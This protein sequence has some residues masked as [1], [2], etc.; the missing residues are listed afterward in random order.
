MYIQVKKDVDQHTLNLAYWS[1]P[2][3][4]YVF[5]RYSANIL[6]P[7]ARETLTIIVS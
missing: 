5:G 6:K 2:V 3:H 1:A 4:R 7:H